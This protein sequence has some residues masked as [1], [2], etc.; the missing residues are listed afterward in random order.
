MNEQGRTS[1]DSGHV[2]RKA[3]SA[4]LDFRLTPDVTLSVDALYQK[5]KSN[6]TI[7]G[8]EVADGVGVPDAG[9]VSRH[10]VQPHNFYQTEETSVG[11]SID[12]RIN[13]AWKASVKFRYGKENRTNADSVL[14]IVNNN[15][16]YTNTLYASMTRFFDKTVDGMLNGA[17]RTGSLEHH[18]VLGVGYQSQMLE[19]DQ[20]PGW[21]PGYDLGTGNIY[22]HSVLTNSA[23]SLNPSLYKYNRINQTALY[24]SDTVDITHRLSILAGLRYTQYRETTWN[25]NGST[26]SLYSANPVSPTFAVMFK[27]TKSA[28]AYFSYVESLEAGGS[29]AITNAN[30][31]TTYG[32]MRSRQYEVGTKLETDRFGGS[33]ALFRVD[34]GY[35]Y[36][37]SQ[38]IYV[39]N[40]KKR[41]LGVDTDGW[42]DLFDN[43]KLA[44]GVLLLNAKSIDIDDSSVDGK[45]P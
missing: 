9:A 4:A 30:Y 36:T 11:A 1:E 34:E 12:Y 43:W 42:I 27:L 15:G 13:N 40:G 39:Q 31:P 26:A 6:G 19:Y 37:N 5:K 22:A 7:F 44:G 3:A 21:Y 28:T 24:A 8:I 2:R 33:I 16:D 29:A 41:Y 35:A 32:P 45:R 17:F 20:E 38:N 23:V 14:D 18:V 25:A 10:Y